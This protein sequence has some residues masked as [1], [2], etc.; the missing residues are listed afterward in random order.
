[1]KP[2]GIRNNNPGNIR[3]SNINWQGKV[4]N[5]NTE[6]EIFKSSF[7]GIRALARNLLTYYDN[8]LDTVRK[9]ITRWAPENE[10]PTTDYIA[11]I[12]R[13]LDVSPD[14][15]LYLPR[16]IV[17]IVKAIIQFENGEQPYKTSEIAKAVHAAGW[18]DQSIVG[19]I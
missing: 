5:N 2:L 7:F 14:E 1:M 19:Q 9:I 11:F 4:K 16:Y 18:E 13:Q 6:Y 12:S 10:N 8:G 3:N 15:Q 17:D